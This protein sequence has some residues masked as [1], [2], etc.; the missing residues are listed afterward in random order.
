[1]KCEVLGTGGAVSDSST[2]YLLE[3]F[4]LVDCGVDIVK[5][6]VQ[7]NKLNEISHIF[8]THRHMDH[9][10]GLE[11]LLYARR[12]LEI[13]IPLTIL[14]TK[15]I[16]E[17]YKTMIVCLDS[18]GNYLQDFDFV[19]LD[20]S[21]LNTHTTMLKDHIGLNHFAVSHMNNTA[22]ALGV[23]VT[24]YKSNTS[25]IITGDTDEV[26]TLF[27][28]DTANE[29]IL[30]FHDMGWTGVPEKFKVDGKQN[31]PSEEEVFNVFG[32]NPNVIGIHTDADL[33][34]YKK[35]KKQVYYVNSNSTSLNYEDVS[36]HK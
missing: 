11:L 4:L 15:E 10:G 22:D 8:I 2:A 9:I 35:A 20:R 18:D 26:P 31:H 3:D 34:K 25:V 19:Q 5:E 17:M 30:V 14:A 1:M 32:E 23:I 36:L 7:S 16:L 21:H 13:K 27:S 12:Q 24:N 6:I 28:K 29:N 33:V